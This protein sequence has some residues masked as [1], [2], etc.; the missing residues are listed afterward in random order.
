MVKI[1]LARIK[2]FASP[3]DTGFPSGAAQPHELAFLALLL[4]ENA[5]C[6]IEAP[7]WGALS[8]LGEAI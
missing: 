8:K 1:A 4:E 5:K 6:A 3:P 7:S 2:R